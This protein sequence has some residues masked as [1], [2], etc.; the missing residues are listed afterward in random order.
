MGVDPSAPGGGFGRRLRLQR[1]LRDVLR[2][3]RGA[4]AAAR[5]RAQRR[6]QDA[7]I[8]LDIDL[9][10]ATFGGA[11]RPHRRHRRRLPDLQRHLLPAGHVA[12][13]LRRLQGPRPDPAG[14]PLVP[15][16]GH[17]DAGLRRLPRVRHGHPRPV[18]GVLRRGPGAH[19][20]DDHHRRSRRASTPAPGSSSPAR[21]RS[22]PPAARPATSTS[23]SSSAS[24]PSFTR[25]GDDLHCTL[26][27]PMTAAALGTTRRPRRR[28]TASSRSTSGPARSPARCRPCAGFGVTHLRGA[29]RG[30][31]R[32]A[33]V[34]CS[35][36]TATGRAAG[37]APARA[38]R[39]CAARSA[40]PAGWLPPTRASSPSCATAS[41]AAELTSALR[42][43]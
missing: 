37:A 8:R 29:G 19:P 38:R 17:D 43:R 16:P 2:R 23:R 7:L 31:L 41:P 10:E 27:V 13:D 25:R 21:A 6:G 9:A 14:R 5:C 4:A 42:R 11:A 20:P 3:R 12:A 15:R 40:R 1:H 35:T 34:A 30:D 28:W 24:T 32:R 22:A 18:P 33:H 26:E 39:G 36:P